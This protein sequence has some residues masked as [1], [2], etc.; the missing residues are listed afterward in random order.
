MKRF[1]NLKP[2]ESRCVFAVDLGALKRNILALKE[3]LPE[4]MNIFGVVKAN[5][6]GL[7][8]VKVSK[9]IESYVYGFCVATYGEAM[10]LRENGIEK[11]IL[12]LGPVEEDCYPSM[13][14]LGI[15]PTIQTLEEAK[16][17]QA[18]SKSVNKNGLYHIAV[19][20]G[21]SRI[22][23][24][25]SKE[26][27]KE[28]SDIYGLEGIQA[29]GIFSHLATMDCPDYSEAIAQ[30]ERFLWFVGSLKEQGI[31]FPIAHIANSIA[32]ISDQAFASEELLNGC[33]YGIS[34]Y[35]VYP[36]EDIT[37][38][39]ISVEPVASLHS[40]VTTLKTVPEGT[41]IGY[42]RTFITKRPTDVATVCCGYADGYPRAISG[43]GDVL[44]N[45]ERF[46]IIGRVC[47]DQLM[48]DVT[49]RKNDMK[50]GD[51]VT[52]FGKDGDEEISLDEIER[53]SGRL[54]YE[55]ISLITPRVTKVYID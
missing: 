25:V 39:K 18:A 14:V 8:S 42:G 6:Y 30:K 34:L 47:M 55:V 16:A 13:A 48:V 11:P 49:D 40:L 27:L 36:A 41:G 10:E 46:H 5:S 17:F 9:A 12:V 52:L 21:M 29:E 53:K 31:T 51:V 22:G 15:R 32:S 4:K 26:G 44:I 20:T 50:V 3:S 33:R 23:L 45:G 54:T 37:R 43:K 19:D 24:P 35:G 2:G 7:G 1:E 28:A 38:K